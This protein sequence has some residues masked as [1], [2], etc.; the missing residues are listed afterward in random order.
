MLTQA[1]KAIASLDAKQWNSAVDEMK[2]RTTSF[3]RGVNTSFK[4]VSNQWHKLDQT[5][6]NL[7]KKM[8]SGFKWAS[9]AVVG[10]AVYMGK[11]SIEAASAFE[12]SSAKFD[13][14]FKEQAAASREWSYAFSKD[15]GMAKR[16]VLTFMGS[17][18]DLFVPLG[19]ARDKAADFSKQVVSLSA[20]LASFNNMPTEDVVRDIHAALTGSA[21]TMK[22]YGV[23]I[24][25]TRIGQELINMGIKGGTKAATDQQ[26]AMATMNL[27]MRGT[28]DAQG[29]AI[30]TSNS[31]ANTMKRMWA[32]VDDLKV[33]IG[34]QLLPAMTPMVQ[35]VST[36]IEKN[37]E[38]ISTRIG[39]YVE[40]TA[41]KIKEWASN[42]TFMLWW[43]QAKLAVLG[44]KVAIA[45]VSSALD[46]AVA[47]Y[48]RLKAA[49]EY[50]LGSDKSYIQAKQTADVYETKAAKRST[51]V[52]RDY[53]TQAQ[54]V[55]AA[56]AKVTALS[57]PAVNGGNTNVNININ[58]EGLQR[59][60]AQ[61]AKLIAEEVRRAVRRG[62]AL[63]A[64]N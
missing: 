61:E 45:G 63:P 49:K 8:A 51:G 40:K 33:A 7:N 38:L 14:V 30:R 32:R 21:E 17:T 50:Y 18:Q 11:E 44:F 26:K 37:Q 5:R 12:E 6:D 36:W 39:E 2:K 23:V 60:T 10:S 35:M 48:Y 28:T 27:I 16:E 20:D 56:Q 55:S 9:A 62:H 64:G 24:N 59:L 15:V 43:E 52:V 31:F 1:L 42:G 46:Y 13:T 25:Q 57:K 54:V 19:F 3:K 58:N 29:D 22:K 53:E 4:A 34:Q 47:G 41:N